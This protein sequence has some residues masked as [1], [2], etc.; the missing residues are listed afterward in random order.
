MLAK[1]NLLGGGNYASH[2][3]KSSTSN[4]NEN[5]KETNTINRILLDVDFMAM[6]LVQMLFREEQGEAFL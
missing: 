5:Q 3:F 1:P 4:D 2:Y 6:A